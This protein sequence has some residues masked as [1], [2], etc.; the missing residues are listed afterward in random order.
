MSLCTNRER[1]LSMKPFCSMTSL[2]VN[3]IEDSTTCQIVQKKENPMKSRGKDSSD[4][5][6]N[7]HRKVEPFCH[8][9]SVLHVNQMKNITLIAHQCQIRLQDMEYTPT[10]RGSSRR[11]WKTTMRQ[12]TYK[13]SCLAWSRGAHWGPRPWAGCIATTSMEKWSPWCPRSNDVWWEQHKTC[14]AS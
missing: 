13:P 8:P 10:W 5:L 11:I 12:P 9:T 7:K 2:A 6:N 3:W 1:E 4:S 14:G